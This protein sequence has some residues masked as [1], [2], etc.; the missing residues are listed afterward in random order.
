ME[1][2]GRAWFFGVP[3]ALHKEALGR[4]PSPRPCL[5]ENR[6]VGDSGPGRFFVKSGPYLALASTQ[7]NLLFSR[8]FIQ[9]VSGFVVKTYGKVGFGRLR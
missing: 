3:G 5:L 1:P 8:A 6:P 2:M 9:S 4:T 7:Q